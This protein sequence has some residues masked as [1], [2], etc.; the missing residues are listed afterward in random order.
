MP[1]MCL[2][3]TY[4]SFVS[5]CRRANAL[6]WLLALQGQWVQKTI[7]NPE[8]FEEDAPLA[9]VGD[10]GAVAIEIWTVDQGYVFD[11]ILVDSKEG[12]AL[13]YR[14]EVWAPRFEK[15]VSVVTRAL[16]NIAM[17]HQHCLSS[18]TS[19]CAFIYHPLVQHMRLVV[20]QHLGNKKACTQ[21]QEAHSYYADVGA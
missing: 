8:Y 6:V 20:G 9:K 19:A 1:V 18:Q 2:V 15:E 11:G 4:C 14:E 21:Q 16:Q 3:A 12:A 17:R 5:V 7:P 10:I 13:R